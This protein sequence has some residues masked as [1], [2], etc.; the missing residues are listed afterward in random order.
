M[1]FLSNPRSAKLR[2]TYMNGFLDCSGDV[3][4]RAG[5]VIIGNISQP[6]Y[7]ANQQSL[8][9]HGRTQM[10]GNLIVNGNLLVSSN[11]IALGLRAGNIDNGIQYGV[12][13]GLNSTAVGSFSGMNHTGQN[14]TFTGSVAG[15]TSST[16][17]FSRT[18]SNNTY[19][20]YRTSA[21]NSAWADSTAVG[22]GAVITASNQIVL[23]TTAETVSIP[24]LTVLNGGSQINTINITALA[25]P[26]NSW[27]GSYI[28]YS[29]VGT[30][31]NQ[32]IPTATNIY[33]TIQIYSNSTTVQTISTLGGN[34]YGCGYNNST[35]IKLRI[36]EL[37]T[38]RSDGFNWILYTD[39]NII[40]GRR[41]L[42]SRRGDGA[43]TAATTTIVTVLFPTDIQS[44]SQTGITYNAGTFTNN[45]GC[46]I[47]CNISGVITFSGNAT[48][49]R[50]LWI[51]HSSVSIGRLCTIDIPTNGSGTPIEPTSLPFSINAKFDNGESFVC[52]V[53]HNAGSTLT[54]SNSANAQTSI[55]V[56][57]HDTC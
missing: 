54:L 5:N 4:L 1:S 28:V 41:S 43:Q 11:N 10:N 51:E 31:L 40:P 46:S 25:T 33:S 8:L 3:V 57:I 52:K 17:Y 13:N 20:G 55:T 22:T 48:G 36:N 9:I 16:T 56:L 21:S 14:N 39:T 24:G 23:G 32:T 19:L 12:P 42:I 49:F 27:Y 26:N 7:N 30:D 45:R 29:N 2:N 15:Q 47:V 35:T 53:Y 18:G 38:L 37:I 44:G 50:A 6:G 34:F